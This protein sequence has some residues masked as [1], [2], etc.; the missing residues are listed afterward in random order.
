[1]APGPQPRLPIITREPGR[2]G[3]LPVTR[4]PE[5]IAALST[6]NTMM[7]SGN[8]TGSQVP[9]PD[10]VRCARPRSAGGRFSCAMMVS[11]AETPA[12]SPP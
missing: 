8:S 9:M 1:M 12:D 10:P 4:P 3:R 2:P 5:R 6:K 7:A 11:M